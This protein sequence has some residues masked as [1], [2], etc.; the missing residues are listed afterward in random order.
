M[1]ERLRAWMPESE[2]S[3]SER[4]E[5]ESDARALM[6]ARVRRWF[7]L[8]TVGQT[9]LIAV[10]LRVSATTPAQ[11]AWRT[12]VVAVTVAFVALN[13]VMLAAAHTHGPAL[14]WIRDRIGPIVQFGAVFGYAI[15]AANA[16]RTHGMVGTFVAMLIAAPYAFRA[17]TW[18]YWLVTIVSVATLTIGIVLLQ[19]VAVTRFG[20]ISAT[21]GFGCFSLVIGRMHNQSLVR[22]QLARATLQRFNDR[23]ATEV[24]EKT[25]VIRAF[26]DRLDGALE[27]ERRRLARDLHDDLGQ[28]LTAIRLD[29]QALRNKLVEASDRTVFSRMSDALDRTHKGVRNI[30]ESLRPR[31]LDEEGLDAAVAWLVAHFNERSACEVAT[32]VVLYD[33]PHPM[34]ALTAFRV[35][36]ES[37]TNIARHA[38]AKRVW[39]TVH[40]GDHDLRIELRDDGPGA[41][42][43]REGRGLRGMRERVLHLGGTFAIQR[44]A[45]HVQTVVS[46]TLPLQPGPPGLSNDQ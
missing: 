33:E 29:L 7:A 46:V 8:L 34:V 17:P 1:L 18:W 3:E 24:A 6:I 36:Q 35:V 28:E 43:I 27:D 32:D 39:I 30:L 22:E 5:F 25:A 4:A 13:L 11:Q 40:G 14:R 23:L 10:T 20:N 15:I 19:P 37:L 12:T 31:I 26:A 38:R 16:Q 45:D 2:L 9:L 21:V 42:S 44:D 41:A